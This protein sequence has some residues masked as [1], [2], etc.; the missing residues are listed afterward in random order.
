MGLLTEWIY[1]AYM[2]FIRSKVE[3]NLLGYVGGSYSGGACCLWMDRG[4]YLG[5]RLCLYL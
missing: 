5:G 4:L 3:G 1:W 2:I